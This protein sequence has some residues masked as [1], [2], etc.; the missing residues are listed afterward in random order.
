MKTKLNKEKIEQNLRDIQQKVEDIND[1]LSG[2]SQ[3]EFLENKEKHLSIQAL[4][5]NIV[6]AVGN[7]ALHITTK[8]FSIGKMKSRK[9]SKF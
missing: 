6:K 4:I 5:T 7:I 1:I 9:L 2:V 3:H 8:K